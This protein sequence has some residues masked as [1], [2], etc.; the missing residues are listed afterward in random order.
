MILLLVYNFSHIFRVESR[1]ASLRM[2]RLRSGI[3][4]SN[5]FLNTEL[6]S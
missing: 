6:V 1:V 2:N 3:S 4:L 5:K